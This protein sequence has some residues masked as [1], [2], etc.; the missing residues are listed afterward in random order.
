MF[1]FFFFKIKNQELDCCN[2]VFHKTVILLSKLDIT[3]WILVAKYA[4][5]SHRIFFSHVNLGF[6]F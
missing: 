1:S 2:I 6:F 5:G 3:F 4:I